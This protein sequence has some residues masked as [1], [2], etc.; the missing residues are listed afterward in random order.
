MSDRTLADDGV[1][2]LNHPTPRALEFVSFRPAPGRSPAPDLPVAAGGAR[3]RAGWPDILHV[4]PGRW[5]LLDVDEPLLAS[6]REVSEGALTDVS[7]KWIAF[8]L[9]GKWARRMLSS[10]LDIGSMLLDRDCAQ[11]CLFDCPCIVASVSDGYAIFVQRSF[12]QAF[13]SAVTGL[14]GLPDSST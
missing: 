14:A 13:A 5:L 10:S 6:L 2:L 8:H 4:A 3:R 12:S 9:A 11:T 1:K 7:G